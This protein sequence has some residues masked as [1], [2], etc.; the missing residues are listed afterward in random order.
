M[1]KGGDTH[2]QTALDMLA[3]NKPIDEIVKYS[4]LPME[5]VLELRDSQATFTAEVSLVRQQISERGLNR[6]Y[7]KVIFKR[8][9]RVLL[10][11]FQSQLRLKVCS[12]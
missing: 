3:D 4:H 7:N 2:V 8:F 1:Q 10:G 6:F 9:L 11:V 12:L 5:K